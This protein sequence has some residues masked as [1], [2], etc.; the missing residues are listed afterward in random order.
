MAEYRPQPENEPSAFSRPVDIPAQ[1]SR[2][3]VSELLRN[4][5]RLAETAIKSGADSEQK[6]LVAQPAEVHG[7]DGEILTLDD[8]V[9]LTKDLLAQR[10]RAVE[11]NQMRARSNE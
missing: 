3:D 2:E 4:A 8:F 6:T 7:P 11:V 1:Q 10:A 9:E 5:M